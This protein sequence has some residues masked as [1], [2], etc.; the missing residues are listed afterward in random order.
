MTDDMEQQGSAGFHSASKTFHIRLIER[1]GPLSL[2]ID[3]GK[4]YL[5]NM[6]RNALAVAVAVVVGIGPMTSGHLEYAS[7]TTR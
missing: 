2:T 3:S 4:P 1:V 5:E 6:V 7:T